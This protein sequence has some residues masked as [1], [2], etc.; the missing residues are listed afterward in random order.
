MTFRPYFGILMTLLVLGFVAGCSDKNVEQKV[1]VGKNRE[2]I[3]YSANVW[4]VS[5]PWYYEVREN[6]K[7]LMPTH[8]IAYRSPSEPALQFVI[9]PAG[10]MVGIVRNNRLVVL[11]DFVS[12]ED[13][14]DGE[15]R[16]AL[17]EKMRK[18]FN[19]GHPSC[20]PME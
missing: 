18:A 2:V 9:V 13:W 11:Y 5:Q 20:G 3:I 7:I 4:E 16:G 15:G 1:S 12:R 14:D 10:D 8:S 6:G 19:E 17:Y